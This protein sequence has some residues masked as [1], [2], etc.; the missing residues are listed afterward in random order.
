MLVCCYSA[1]P[2]IV[3]PEV[4]NLIAQISPCN[5]Q[6]LSESPIGVLVFDAGKT[7]LINGYFLINYNMNM[8]E[9]A[10]TNGTIQTSY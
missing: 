3:K 4:L 5:F 9:I 1:P 8:L 7:C 10:P 2:D 6:P